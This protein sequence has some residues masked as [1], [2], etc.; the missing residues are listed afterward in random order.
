MLTFIAAK[1]YNALLFNCIE[2]ETEK[3]L[4]KNENGFQIKCSTTA[5]FWQSAEF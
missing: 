1:I 2:L 3:I 5:R 4:R